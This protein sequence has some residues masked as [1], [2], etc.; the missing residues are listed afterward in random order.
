M[1]M[2]SVY[3]LM[4]TTRSKMLQEVKTLQENKFQ[5]L[6][7]GSI[8]CLVKKKKKQNQTNAQEKTFAT[9]NGNAQVKKRATRVVQDSEQDSVEV[10]TNKILY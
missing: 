7:G 2:E 10:T 6:C 3:I 9:N 5:V 8:T 1:S 4:N